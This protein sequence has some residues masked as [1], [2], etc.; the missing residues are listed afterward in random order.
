MIDATYHVMDV[1]DGRNDLITTTFSSQDAYLACDKYYKKNP[2]SDPRVFR[3]ISFTD[4]V[5]APKHSEQLSHFLVDEEN[6]T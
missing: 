6:S 2:S 4:I 5:R 3:V 1:K